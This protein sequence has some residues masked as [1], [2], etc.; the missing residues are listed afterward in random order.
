MNQTEALQWCE[1][2]LSHLSIIYSL[3]GKAKISTAISS[4]PKKTKLRL[5]ILLRLQE[6]DWRWA[7][8]GL[9]VCGGEWTGGSDPG[10]L[11]PSKVSSFLEEASVQLWLV[12]P[13][14]RKIDLYW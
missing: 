3:L 1:N 9:Q 12:L 11:L 5:L 13:E 2:V 14:E 6:R 7:G 10:D 4:N 8:K